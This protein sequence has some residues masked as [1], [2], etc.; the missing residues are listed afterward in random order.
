MLLIPLESL[1]GLRMLVGEE[2][3]GN[4]GEVLPSR[5][6]SRPWNRLPPVKF[7]CEALV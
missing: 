1:V 4:V 6:D 7:V 5:G 3:K 2:G